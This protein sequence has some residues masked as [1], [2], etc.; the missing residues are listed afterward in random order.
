MA[1][2]KTLRYSKVHRPIFEKNKLLGPSEK[3]TIQLSETT[4][5]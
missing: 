2:K 3:S 1:N 5:R 4:L